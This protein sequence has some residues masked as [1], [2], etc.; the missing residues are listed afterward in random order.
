MGLFAIVVIGGVAK[1]SRSSLRRQ[2]SV[3]KKMKTQTLVVFDTQ[4]WD[5]HTRKSIGK[6]KLTIHG[7][8]FV[9]RC[10][11][12][13][14]FFID[15]VQLISPHNE[16]CIDSLQILKHGE[17]PHPPMADEKLLHDYKAKV[18]KLKKTE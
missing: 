6:L 18:E 10:R 2:F 8:Q 16:S 14:F 9:L 12:E 17:H 4:H 3:S 7:N 5:I 1:T 15:C 13:I 11:Y